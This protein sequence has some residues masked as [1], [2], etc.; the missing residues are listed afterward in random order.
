MP[1]TAL[2]ARPLRRPSPHPRPPPP[3]GLF[4]RLISHHHLCPRLPLGQS[5]LKCLLEFRAVARVRP[6]LVRLENN[7]RGPPPPPSP[8]LSSLYTFFPCS[9][10]FL[11]EKW[12]TRKSRKKRS[13][14]EKSENSRK[15]AL[16]GRMPTPSSCR[17]P[18]RFRCTGPISS[19]RSIYLRVCRVWPRRRT[20]LR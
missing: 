20:F 9:N 5:W 17:V 15:R 10:D 7:V 6:P 11:L 14:K 3:P 18:A 19:L 8:T 4:L 13:R 2:R 12:D 16:N 1:P